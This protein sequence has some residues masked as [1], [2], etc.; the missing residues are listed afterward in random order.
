MCCEKYFLWWLNICCGF[1]INGVGFGEKSESDD[2]FYIKVKWYWY[3][4]VEFS[5]VYK[6]MNI[7]NCV[8]YFIWKNGIWFRWYGV[9]ICKLWIFFEEDNFKFLRK[10]LNVKSWKFVFI[11]D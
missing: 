7:V 2:E 6:K 11:C 8:M 3:K 1:C 4:G 9:W 10:F 5:F